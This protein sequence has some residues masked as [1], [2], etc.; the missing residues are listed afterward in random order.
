MYKANVIINAKNEEEAQKHIHQLKKN[1]YERK[2]N[3]YW[4]EVFQKADGWTVQVNRV[5]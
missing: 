5:F 1:G 3:C 2:E 4:T